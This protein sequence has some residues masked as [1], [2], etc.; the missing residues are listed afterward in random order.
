MTDGSGAGGFVTAGHCGT[1]GTSAQSS[2]RSG[3]GTF[4]QSVLPGNDGAFLAAT[5]DWSVTNLAS[6]HNAGGPQAVSGS[7][8]AP[9]GS[10][11]RRSGPTAGWHCGTIQ[12]R[13]QSA[14]HPEGTVR[15]PDPHQRVRRAR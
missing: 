11:V 9:K 15:G 3:S 10:A 12:A 7:A 1:V 13:N 5:S 4:R 6:R 2:D 8:R 14:T